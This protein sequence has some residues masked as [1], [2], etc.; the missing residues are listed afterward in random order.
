MRRSCGLGEHAE[1]PHLAGHQEGDWPEHASLSRAGN[2]NDCS[3]QSLPTSHQASTQPAGKGSDYQLQQH[4]RQRNLEDF[5]TNQLFTQHKLVKSDS[6]G[7]T[8]L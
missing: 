7:K 5:F 2:S 6:H 8:T 1:V 4:S 3:P